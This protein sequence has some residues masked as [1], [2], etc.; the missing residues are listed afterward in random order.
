VK[1]GIEQLFV[2]QGSGL[3]IEKRR[4]T[5]QILQVPMEAELAVSASGTGVI[6]GFRWSQVGIQLVVLP[7]P[8]DDA[9]TNTDQQLTPRR[10]KIRRV[11]ENVSTS[12]LALVD[13][14]EHCGF[15]IA[16]ASGRSRNSRLRTHTVTASR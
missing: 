10:P 8:S 9:S 13:A 14:A 12:N 11:L 1:Y 16:S 6:K 2:E 4:G 7:T 15:E 5:R 3:D